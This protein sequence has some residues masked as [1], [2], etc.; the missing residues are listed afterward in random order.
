MSGL[1]LLVIQD[2]AMEAQSEVMQYF[3]E[4][5]EETLQ[6]FLEQALRTK[7]V[8]LSPEMKEEIKAHSPENYALI[9][10]FINKA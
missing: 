2:A 1:D 4:I 5:L 9:E 3:A 7:W 8:S 10:D 6:P